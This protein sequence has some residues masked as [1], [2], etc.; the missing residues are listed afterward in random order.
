MHEHDKPN[1]WLAIDFDGTL[2]TYNT[3]IGAD[4]VGEAIQ[5]MVERVKR[6]LAAGWEVR[7]FTARVYPL[8]IVRPDDDPRLALRVPHPF[9][10]RDSETAVRVIQDFCRRHFGRVLTI[11]CVKDYGMA[12]LYDDRCVQVRPN[13]G[14][15]VGGSS[16]GLT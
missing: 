10:G 9:G 12:E 2:A 13:T 15:L 11:T 7:I 6:W 1:G 8:L 16:R 4:H 3:W 14:E 5:P